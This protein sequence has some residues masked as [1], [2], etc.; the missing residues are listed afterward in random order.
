M[1]HTLK[2]H[3]EKE[4]SDIKRTPWRQMYGEP[5]ATP[6]RSIDNELIERGER[7]EENTVKTNQ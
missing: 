1:P 5:R 4:E 2:S 7:I 3:Q 6:L